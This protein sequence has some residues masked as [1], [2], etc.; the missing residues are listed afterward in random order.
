MLHRM[1]G[2]LPKV[3][4]VPEEQIHLTLRFIGEVESNCYLDIKEKLSALSCSAFALGLQG[5]GH[6]PP[7][8]KPRVLWAGVQ[9]VEQVVQLKRKIDVCLQACEIG[10]DK[11]KFSPHVTFSRLYNTPLKRVTDFLSGNSF[12][13]SREFDV[14]CFHLY[15]SRLLAKGAVHTLEAVYP[16]RSC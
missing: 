9:P 4:A 16:L 1:G 11:R 15:S 8:G 14:D 12:L 10:P 13:Q 6:F 3:K 7:R 5:V 2:C